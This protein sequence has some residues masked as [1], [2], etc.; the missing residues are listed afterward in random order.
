M[1]GVEENVHYQEMDFHLNKGDFLLLTSDGLLEAECTGDIPFGIKGI[2][3]FLADAV[4]VFY[5]VRR[6]NERVSATEII[7][8][9]GTPFQKK[10]VPFKIISEKGLVVYP[11]EEVF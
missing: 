2:E 8:I 4:V 7:K 5:N 11:Q 3:E 1:I 9:R 6:Q 10:I